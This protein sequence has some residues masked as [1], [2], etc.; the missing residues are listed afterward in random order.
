M[1]LHVDRIFPAVILSGGRSPEPK[2][3]A[4]HVMP[5]VVEA[6][7]AFAP[8]LVENGLYVTSQLPSESRRTFYNNAFGT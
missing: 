3:S 7:A 8:L 5:S 6:S 1:P 4:F 2:G